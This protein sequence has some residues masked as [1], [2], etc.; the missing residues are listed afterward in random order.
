MAIRQVNPSSEE[1]KKDREILMQPSFV[2][3]L[4]IPKLHPIQVL[5]DKRVWDIQLI[6][7]RNFRSPDFFGQCL[8]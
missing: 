1:I 7:L 5:R 4:V 8:D 2:T 6:N 3:S